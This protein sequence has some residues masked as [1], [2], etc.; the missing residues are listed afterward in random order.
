MI[1]SRRQ[2]RWTKATRVQIHRGSLEGSELFALEGETNDK[3]NLNQDGVE[4][5]EDQGE[6]LSPADA[7]REG[8]VRPI[9]GG[10]EGLF[11][12]VTL[13]QPAFSQHRALPFHRTLLPLWPATERM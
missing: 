7:G 3:S 9:S 13:A 4:K 6:S 11:S 5:G 2:G 12:R 8:E 10:V 1:K